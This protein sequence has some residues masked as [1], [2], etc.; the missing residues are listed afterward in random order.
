MMLDY[1]LLG[2]AILIL[3]SV[4]F[5]KIFDNLG[6][7]TLILFIALGML[8]GS[9]GIGGIYFNEALIAQNIAII[10]PKSKP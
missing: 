8:A 3:L 10:A 6:L 7:P 9:E 5:A 4:I 1:F 2:S